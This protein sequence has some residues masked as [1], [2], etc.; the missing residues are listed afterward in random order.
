MEGDF[1]QLFALLDHPVPR[2]D[3]IEIIT[4]V[5]RHRARRSALLAAA[6]LLCAATVATA[7]VPGTGLNDIVRSLLGGTSTATVR[8]PRGSSEQVQLP[9][10]PAPP[11]GI[12]FVP[13]DRAT[14]TFR[15]DQSSGELYV[16]VDTTSSIRITATGGHVARYDLTPSGVEIDNVGSTASYEL[17]LP[18]TLAHATVRVSERLIASRERGK[19]ECGERPARGNGCVVVLQR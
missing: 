12:A 9:A 15:A 13:G 16:R 5:R 17:V 11:L 6:A 7:A 14:I 19:L 18:A 2:V 10:V 4:R 3:A 8:P 1:A